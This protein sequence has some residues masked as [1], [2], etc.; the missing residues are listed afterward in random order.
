M[1]K[2]DCGYF[3]GDRPC[4]PHKEYGIKCDN[5]SYYRPIS[6]K[7]LIVKLDAI[8][9]V[10]RTTS[11]LPPLKKKFP[12][13]YI[14]WCTRESAKS[15]FNNNKN[16]DEVITVEDDA[17][18]RINSEEYDLVINLDTS[19]ISSAIAS[20][21]KADEKIGFVL[22]KRGYVEA[23]S[24]AAFVWLEMSAFD[25][26]KK[27][28]TK[29]YQQIMYDI[30]GFSDPIS[31]PQLFVPDKTKSKI[32]ERLLQSGLKKELK[33]IGLN[34][35]IGPKW[36][37]KGWPEKNWEQLITSLSNRNYN[38]LLLGGPEETERI[39]NLKNKFPFLIDTGTKNSITEFAAIVNECDLVITCDTFALHIATAMGKNLIVLVG[40]TSA[41]ELYL[42]E[43]GV[44]LT[45]PFEC[46]CYYRKYCTEKVS[47]MESILPGTVLI[48]IE[49]ILK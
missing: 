21:A 8:G 5:C 18:F 22:H 36:P 4:D 39:K 7:I 16:V 27:A 13:S 15:L 43:K 25:D 17:F 35:G 46:K 44:K 33:T 42:Y 6:F 20:N 3:K 11:I 29:S 47:C 10:L 12:D 45:A 40:P 31:Q 14:V 32:S 23:T 48:E 19:K 34:I 38:L 41:A 37:S 24:D 1:L 26:V 2:T 30:L 49:K 9:D 28:N